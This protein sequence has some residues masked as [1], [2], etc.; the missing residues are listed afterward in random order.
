MLDSRLFDVSERNRDLT[1]NLIEP[2]LKGGEMVLFTLI[3]WDF[4]L[5]PLITE[6]LEI[7]FKYVLVQVLVGQ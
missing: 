3:G 5:I 2:V 4:L 6:K 7:L 1:E